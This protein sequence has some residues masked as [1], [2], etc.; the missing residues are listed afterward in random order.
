MGADLHYETLKEFALVNRNGSTSPLRNDIIDQVF[1][2]SSD[3]VSPYTYFLNIKA[4]ILQV[5]F[6]DLKTFENDPGHPI[7]DERCK[8][9]AARHAAT[10]EDCDLYWFL[11][12]TPTIEEDYSLYTAL[13]TEVFKC[14]VLSSMHGIV[15]YERGGMMERIGRLELNPS[16]DVFG[17]RLHV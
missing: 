1:M 14:I 10:S 4:E 16:H 6:V 9:Y 15:V 11:Q 8:R 5:A 3:A 2:G 17:Q 13:C 7:L 12:L